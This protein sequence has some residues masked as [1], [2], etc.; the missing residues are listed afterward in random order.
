MPGNNVINF[1]PAARA[2][3]RPVPADPAAERFG[4]ALASIGLHAPTILH[5]DFARFAD[6]PAGEVF[7]HADETSALRLIGVSALLESGAVVH[8]LEDADNQTVIVTVFLTP[9][10]QAAVAMKPGDLP[11]QSFLRLRLASDAA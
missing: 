10:G 8:V 1:R 3:Q 6:L 4:S 2:P 11:W 9:T 7:V 5:A